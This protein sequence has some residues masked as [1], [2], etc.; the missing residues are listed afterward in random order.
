MFLVLKL[1]VRSPLRSFGLW[2]SSCASAV[3]PA[4]EL[5]RGQEN[6]LLFGKSVVPKM[7]T[8]EV[9]EGHAFSCRISP[10]SCLGIGIYAKTVWFGGISYWRHL[11]LLPRVT[12]LVSYLCKLM[13]YSF[14]V[15]HHIKLSAICLT[16][17][18]RTLLFIYLFN[19][20]SSKRRDWLFL[21]NEI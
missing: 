13:L 2:Y 16:F 8:S 14:S 18:N 7:K 3:F 1:H 15:G 5:L 11:L 17:V 9:T 21:I 12:G 4:G 20:K 6:F 19:I 10:V